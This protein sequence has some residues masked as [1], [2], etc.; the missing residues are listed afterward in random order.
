MIKDI[1]ET[2]KMLLDY[3][4][5]K[6]ESILQEIELEEIKNDYI[7]SCYT[8]QELPLEKY[9]HKSVNSHGW[10]RI[11]S[12]QNQEIQI[13][14][15]TSPENKNLI[16]SLFV[17]RVQEN[18]AEYEDDKEEFSKI[19][20][21]QTKVKELQRILE[22]GTMETL[23]HSKLNDESWDKDT[24]G[25][26]YYPRIV[27]AKMY[28][29]EGN[30][31]TMRL[32]DEVDFQADLEEAL[33]ILEQAIC[34]KNR[35]KFDHNL[36]LYG[37]PG[38]GKTYHTAIY[39]VAISLGKPVEEMKKMPYEWIM[40]YY[41][42]L[43]K[44]N[45]IALTTFH[46]SYGY[47]EFIEG[48][49]P[50]TGR[51]GNI[52]YLQKDGVF[53]AFCKQA[54][55]D[56]KE[57]PRVFIIDEIN[58]GNIS[59]IFGELIT[60]IEDTKRD[61]MPQALSVTLP[62]SG[63][64]FSVPNNVYIIGTMNTADRSIAL[65]DTALRRRFQFIEMMP[66]PNVLQEITI[67]GEEPSQKLIV[68]DMLTAINNRIEY[69]YDREH[70]IGHAFFVKLKAID[71]DKEKLQ[72]LG[73]IFR[74]SVI[75]LLQEYFFED[76]QKIQY[77]LGDNG[78]QWEDRFVREK[79]LYDSWRGRGSVFKKDAPGYMGGEELEDEILTTQYEIHDEAF[80]CLKS[81][82]QII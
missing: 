25:K 66:D 39:A 82:I 20:E 49:I 43:K 12:P 16:L 4:I 15:F 61:G 13:F 8:K 32:P 77:V 48:I 55:D 6:Q 74:K 44:D 69:L 38:T 35:R 81:Y 64:S 45:L 21:I 1:K 79:K 59:K 62:Y 22:K 46:Q 73:N 2:L 53:K 7:L 33:T 41:N 76:Y 9:Y 17:N 14:Y 51:D 34:C 5:N 58:R 71:D 19:Q 10:L 68:S 63:E 37:P 27:F 57:R 65:I 67:S 36:M 47:E 31:N 54:K 70:T 80:D 60:L 42:K 72:C 11:F 78:K 24:F 28:K 40:S 56:V 50:E 30:E 3:H 18:D 26:Y 23:E 29:L 52:R 75:P